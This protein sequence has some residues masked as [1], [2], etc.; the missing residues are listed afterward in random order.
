MGITL[1]HRWKCPWCAAAR[2]GIANVAAEVSL[3]EVPHPRHERVAL[4][5]ASGQERIPVLVDGH[6][7]VVGSRRI[8]RHMYA[9]YGGPELARSVA[10]LDAEIAALD[11]AGLT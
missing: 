11:A 10:E 1:Y 7:V 9:R 3:V 5:E 8:V 4:R 2:Q 6:E